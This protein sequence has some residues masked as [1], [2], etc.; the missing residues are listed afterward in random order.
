MHDPLVML[1]EIRLIGLDVWHREPRGHDS[2]TVCGRIPRTTLARIWWTARHV[3]HLHLRWWPAF[4]IRR[5]ITDHCDHCGKRFRW[6]QARH[7]YQSTDKVWHDVCMSLRHVRGQLD[8]ITGYVRG[9]ADSD[10]RWRAEYRLKGI[11]EVEAEAGA[12]LVAKDG[13]R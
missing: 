12:T 5:W 9:T 1:C 2:G 10:A 6:R 4:N 8:D 11:D 7:S 13:Q 3:H